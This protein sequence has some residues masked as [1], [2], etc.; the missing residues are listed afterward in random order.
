MLRGEGADPGGDTRFYQELAESL[1]GI[2]KAAKDL[3]F[4]PSH[5]PARGQ[6]LERTHGQL[7]RLLDR[8]HHL[9]LNISREGFSLAKT[10]IGRDQPL[11]K[12][13][14]GD[15]FLRKIRTLRLLPGLRLEDLQHLTEML[16]M[17]PSDLAIQGG[18]RAFLRGRQVSTVEV[19]ELELKFT[20]RTPSLLSAAP[21][22]GGSLVREEG[23]VG[24]ALDQ[25]GEGGPGPTRGGGGEVAVLDQ[26]GASG[27]GV[28]LPFLQE[29]AP[30]D[31]EALI[32]ELQRTDRPARYEYL[33]GELSE[34]G[35][36]ALAQRDLGPYLRILTTFALE[37]HPMNAKGENLVSIVQ[38]ALT[39]L[40]EGAG[41]D[42]LIEAFCRGGEVS[43]DDLVHLL[44]FMKGQV[45]GPLVEQ[46]LLTEETPA[47][48]KL[49][50]LLV[51]MGTAALP[52]IQA[53]LEEASW[54]AA[55]RL[56][57]LL[58][59]LTGPEVVGILR[60]LLQHP[61]PR[62]RRETT[63]MAGQL[64]PEL[65]EGLILKALEDDQTS[66]RQ[67]A[68]AQLGGLKVKKA[69]PHLQRIAEER[70]GS[71][72]LEEQKAAITAL[73]VIGAS[74]AVPTLIALLHRK[75]WFHRK[76]TDE[77]RIAAAYALGSVGR[78]EAVEALRAVMKSAPP[79]LRQACEVALHRSP[80]GSPREG[81]P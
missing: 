31:L 46:L 48:R 10:P 72:D 37:L 40:V 6:A 56:L 50:E 59:R 47:R 2:K 43:E 70:P 17:D 62:L 57:P 22:Q 29:E 39:T 65:S 73:G 67:A 11:L 77:L 27:G 79:A 81:S 63:R 44:L 28:A 26:A 38:T 3:L 16:N 66:V 52:A 5:H 32:A 64:T 20:E 25:E 30:A 60:R 53:V 42:L 34:R 55:R 19:E 9:A 71:R 14:A 33:V 4:Y 80:A 24:S 18:S 51:M 15:L 35:R 49:T 68:I 78:P 7:L 54:E 61:D 45:A 76:V 75:S 41:L 58:Q 1:A 69:V 23:L 36:T 13:F 74:E 21:N 12:A 8:H